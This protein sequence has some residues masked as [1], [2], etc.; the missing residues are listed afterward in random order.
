MSL[1]IVLITIGV[2]V[3]AFYHQ[4]VI[5][6]LSLR[7]YGVI[8]QKE[9]YRILTHGL[10]HADWA[11]LLVNMYVLYMFGRLCE[12]YFSVFFSLSSSVLFV[13]FY[14]AALVFSGLFSVY[15][16]RKQ[17]GYSAIGASGVVMA[18]VFAT[19]FFD[20]W[21]KLWFFGVIPI[22]GIVFGGLYLAYSFYMDKKNTDNIGHDAHLSGAIFGLLFPI[23]L[24]PSLLSHFISQLLPG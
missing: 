5:S 16:H 6:R 19:I 10:V 12:T 15:K 18:V 17:P 14:L 23:I 4:Q 13:L 9:Y 21:N 20:P 7:S 8:E 3:Y 1:I 2:S 11:H 22:P 24:K